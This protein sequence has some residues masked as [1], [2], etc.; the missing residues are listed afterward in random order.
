MHVHIIHPMLCFHVNLLL[1]SYL[2]RI[3]HRITITDVNHNYELTNFYSI[4]NVV[5]H[6]V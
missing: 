1:F 4:K 2:R 6:I 5:I 3:Y